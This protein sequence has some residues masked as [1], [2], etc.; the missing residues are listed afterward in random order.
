MLKKAIEEGSGNVCLK[1]SL[2]IIGGQ[3]K[4]YPKGR[5]P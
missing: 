3:G 4:E 5:S 2:S 1:N